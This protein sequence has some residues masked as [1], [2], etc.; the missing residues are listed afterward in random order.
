MPSKEFRFTIAEDD[1][2]FLFLM[3]HVISTA[4]PGSSLSTFTNA[5]D[6]LHHIRN[7]GADIVVT[8]HG[9]G[10]MSG[11]DMIREL[12]QEGY[13]L[14]IIMVSGNLEAEREARK[15]G[16][17]EFLHKDVALQHLVPRVKR[18]LGVG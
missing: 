9:M 11:T 16:A 2:D 7:S 18:H 15:A 5:E 12:R 13:K 3:H 17:T 8:N 1:E 4:F 10:V 6:A 14:P